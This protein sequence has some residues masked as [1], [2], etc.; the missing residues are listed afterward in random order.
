MNTN[1]TAESLSAS[2]ANA[3]DRHNT[4]QPVGKLE[5][6]DLQSLSRRILAPVDVTEKLLS[7]GVLQSQGPVHAGDDTGMHTFASD[8]LNAVR[9]AVLTAIVE[10]VVEESDCVPEQIV[11]AAGDA[12]RQHAANFEKKPGEKREF[13]RFPKGVV[14]LSGDVPNNAVLERILK[15][16]VVQFAS[17]GASE[18]EPGPFERIAT[19]TAKV[20]GAGALAYGAAGYLRGRLNRPRIQLPGTQLPGAKGVLADTLAGVAANTA[21]L[22]RVGGRIGAGITSGA[23]TIA[24][25]LAK[26]R[27]V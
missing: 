10:R 15:D 9:T 7:A 18:E 19:N 11:M 23:E 27:A 4:G 17:Y 16:H 8:Q 6:H 5:S 12:L 26:R 3:I 1:Q 21:D 25:L 2:L 24:S 22:R 14:Q 20:A 13:C